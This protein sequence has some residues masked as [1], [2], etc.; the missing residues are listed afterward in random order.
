ML[1]CLYILITL[2]GVDKQQ[3]TPTLVEE[4]RLKFFRGQGLGAGEVRFDQG[5]QSRDTLRGN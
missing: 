2:T 1:F 3:S 5:D 4:P